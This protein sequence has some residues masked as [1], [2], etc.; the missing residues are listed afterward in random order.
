M[1]DAAK[2]AGGGLRRD[3]GEVENLQVSR[4]GPAD[5]VSRADM[6]AEEILVTNLQQARPGYPILTEERGAI[7]GNDKTHRW[8]IDP[9]D[10]TTNFLHGIPHFAISIALERENVLVAG[11]VYHP[12]TG[13][14]YHAER[15][16][17]AWLNGRYRL[18]VAGRS[19]L[20]DAVLTCGAPH[21]D[22][23][24]GTQ[25]TSELQVILPQ[26][27]GLRRFGAA[28]LDLAYVA[29][30]RAD[31]YWERGI[32]AWDI[33]AGI[34]LVREAGGFVTDFQNRNRSLA[35]G[36]IIAGNEAIHTQLY[37]ILKN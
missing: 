19:Q 16:N 24:M 26:I 37:D 34:V 3:F 13:E 12:L 20:R 35:T 31:G 22:S 1:L 10:G 32:C 29:A 11:L 25:F 18:R 6:R 28:S 36:E 23:A 21:A 8:I 5:F 17:G 2:K 15:G 4:K 30:G 14:I 33:A 7:E 9:L 27:A